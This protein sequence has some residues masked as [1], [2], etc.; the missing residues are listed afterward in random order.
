MTANAPKSRLRNASMSLDVS[1]DRGPV[2]SLDGAD[3]QFAHGDVAPRVWRGAQSVC[4]DF[5]RWSRT[6]RRTD[7]SLQMSN[8][9]LLGRGVCGDRAHR[10]LACARERLCKFWDVVTIPEES[11]HC[12]KLRLEGAACGWTA[13]GFDG[14][15]GAMGV[16]DDASNTILLT[17]NKPQYDREFW[18]RLWSKTLR[19][20]A[21]KVA[22]RPPNA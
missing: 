20:Q 13:R 21:E 3:F 19:E 14:K 9:R 8:A 6:A 12:F 16:D 5:A 11:L 7:E 2:S 17:N 1:R 18:D 15:N 4:S 10:R 22:S